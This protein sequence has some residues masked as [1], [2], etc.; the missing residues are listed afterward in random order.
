MTACI[1]HCYADVCCV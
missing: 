1:C